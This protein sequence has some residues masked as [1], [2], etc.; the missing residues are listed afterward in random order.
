[1]QDFLFATF[2]YAAVN[3]FVCCL[4]YQRS[5]SANIK[6]SLENQVLM[7]EFYQLSKGWTTL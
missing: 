4:R 3:C 7:T 5:C 2:L 1:M 6:V